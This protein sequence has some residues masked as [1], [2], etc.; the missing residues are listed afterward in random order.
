MGICMMSMFGFKL[1]MIS[2]GDYSYGEYLYKSIF[3]IIVMDI[4]ARSLER[5]E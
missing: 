4:V 1:A 2:L 3:T 5:N